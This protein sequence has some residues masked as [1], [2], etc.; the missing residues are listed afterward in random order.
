MSNTG[1]SFSRVEEKGNIKVYHRQ[2]QKSVAASHEKKEALLNKIRENEVSRRKESVSLSLHP[3]L[4]K[5]LRWMGVV[6]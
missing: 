6:K 2:V 1:L 5:V 4:R 3:W